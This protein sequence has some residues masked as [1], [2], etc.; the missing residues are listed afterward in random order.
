MCSTSVWKC[1]STSIRPR[2][3]ASSP[4]AVEVELV[5]GALA[6]GG[7]QHRVGGDLLAA[8][9][10]C[11]SVPPSCRST[12]AT[13]SPKPEGHARSRRWYCSAS[14][15]SSSQKSSIAGALLDHGDLGAERGEHRGVLDADHAGADDDHRRRD[16]ARRSRISSESTIV[17]PSKSTLAGRAGVRAGGDDDLL[18]GRRC[19]VVAGVVDARAC[20]GRR[21][22]PSPASSATWLRDSW[23]RMTSISRPTTCWVRADRSATVMSSLT[24]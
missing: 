22:R 23:L 7:V 8:T 16:A 5:G 17:L 14:T 18:G 21:T 13:V 12:A 11:V 4:A 19:A 9:R 6:A 20:A 1:S 24:R 3:S 15:I 10:A 2:S